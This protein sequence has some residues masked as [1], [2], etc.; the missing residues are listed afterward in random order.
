MAHNLD[1][2]CFEMVNKIQ[3]ESDIITKQIDDFYKEHKSKKDFKELAENKFSEQ[4]D[5]FRSKY[6]YTFAG[7]INKETGEVITINT[8]CSDKLKHVVDNLTTYIDELGKSSV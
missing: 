7:L 3:Q 2:L 1:S 6:A 4:I 8:D 5:E